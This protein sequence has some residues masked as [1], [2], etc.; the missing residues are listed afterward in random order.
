M[1]QLPDGEATGH[2]TITA[3][4]GRT[5]L[6]ENFSRSVDVEHLAAGLYLVGLRTDAGMVYQA[7]LA[8]R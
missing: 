7:R 1:L 4:D 6:Q 5:A 2:R 8:K 3:P